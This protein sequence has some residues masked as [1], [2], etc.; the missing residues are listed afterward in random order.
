MKQKILITGG[1][2]LIGTHLT[3]LLLEKGFEVVH[4]SRSPGKTDSLVKVYKWD[5][6]KG[7]IDSE[8]FE[9]VQ[10]IIHLAGADVAEERWTEERKEVILNSR[11]ASAALLR[12]W[13]AHNSNTVTTLLSP[14]GIAYYGTDAGSR[15][16]TEESKPGN[17][18]L[19]E[20]TKA[21]EKSADEIGELGIRT[22]K[23]RIGIVLSNKGGAL[24]ELARPIKWGV[25]VPLGSGDQVMSWIHI[26]DLCEMFI[27]GLE[28]KEMTGVFNAV[29]PN[30]V[31]NKVFTEQTAK[32]LHRPAFLPPVP[33]ILLKLALGEKASIVLDGANVSPAKVVEEGFSFRYPNLYP[34]LQNLLL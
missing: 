21:W 32:V 24:V 17:D 15:L 6:N 13:L 3:R 19:A 23:F 18:F 2:G 33:G 25:A 28:S 14:S 8:A 30:P 12:K 34:A 27:F 16:L 29:A 20:V 26:D 31:T 7:Y 22:V 1:S 9:D 4:L 5:I 11:T 10:C